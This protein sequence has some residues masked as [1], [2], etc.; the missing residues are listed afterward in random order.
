MGLQL[1]F[2]VESDKKSKS[3]WIYIKDTIDYF[4][5]YDLAHVK[6]SPIYMHGKGNYKIKEREI[7]KLVSQYASMTKTNES[8]VIYCFDCDDYD[9][10]KEDA[11]FLSDAQ[12]YCERRGYDFVWF[13]KDIECVY[14]GR[15]VEDSQKTKEAALFKKK[16][17]VRN[18]KVNRLSVDE[19]Q[20]NTS[21]IMKIFDKYLKRKR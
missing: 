5:Q 14:V 16:K 10:K 2:A 1:I 12:Q 20:A 8:R 6:L 9:M 4:Y 21:N 15:K 3:D 18:I 11:D 17:A 13:C 7:R 19:Y